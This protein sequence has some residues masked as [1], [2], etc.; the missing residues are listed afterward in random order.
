MGWMRH[1]FAG[2]IL[3]LH[4]NY[5]RRVVRVAHVLPGEGIDTVDTQGGSPVFISAANCKRWIVREGNVEDA[6][7]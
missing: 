5:T 1:A 4:F 3:V 2:Q 7:G 6:Q